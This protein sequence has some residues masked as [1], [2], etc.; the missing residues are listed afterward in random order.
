MAAPSANPFS[1]EAWLGIDEHERAGVRLL[2]L[3]HFLQGLGIAFFSTA[4]LTLF[5]HDFGPEGLAQS[6]L[7][8]GAAMLVS[9]RVYAHFEHRVELVRF[10]P[11][12]VLSLALLSLGIWSGMFLSHAPWFLFLVVAVFRVHYLISNLEF[13]GLTSLLFNVRQSKRL[14]GII[15]SADIPAKILGFLSVYLLLPFTGERDLFLLSAIFF[16]AS[17]AVVYLFLRRFAH[18]HH[19]HHHSHGHLHHSPEHFL[20]RFFGNRFILL[21]SLFAFLAG[22]VLFMLDFAFYGEVKLKFKKSE[23]LSLFLSLFLTGAMTFTFVVKLLFSSF[24]LQRAG[25]RASLLLF[26]G[27]LL[28]GS[29]AILFLPVQSGSI[30]TMLFAFMGLYVLRDAMRFTIYDPAFLSLFQ[31]LTRALRLQGHTVI[32]GMVDA[33][34]LATAGGLLLLLLHLDEN[35]EPE[36]LLRRV[37]WTMAALLALAIPAFLWAHREWVKVLHASVR[38]RFLEGDALPAADVQLRKLMAHTFKSGEPGEVIYGLRLL[39]QTNDPQYEKWLML[40]LEHAA[41]EV[42]AFVLDELKARGAHIALK[43]LTPLFSSADASVRARAL[44]WVA[45]D[46]LGWKLLPPFDEMREGGDRRSALSG[47]LSNPNAEAVD[48]GRA[49]LA[50]YFASNEAGNLRDA[51]WISGEWGLTAF[52]SEQMRLM[53]HPDPDVRGSA[54]E[55]AVKT[56][57]GDA[58]SNLIKKATL[59]PGKR[60][61]RQLLRFG[62]EHLLQGANTRTEEELALI[63]KLL[64]RTDTPA[65]IEFLSAQC[66]HDNQEVRTAAIASLHHLNHLPAGPLVHQLRLCL[67]ANHRRLSQ[68]TSW[69]GSLPQSAGV[70]NALR[71]ELAEEVSEALNTTGLLSSPAA[72]QRARQGLSAASQEMRADG[73]EL[74][75]ECLPRPLRP[76]FAQVLEHIYLHRALPASR[77]KP[78]QSEQQVLLEI[79]SSW[80]H[81]LHAWTLAAVVHALAALPADEPCTD[82][83]LPS[84]P[85]P[86][87]ALQALRDWQA[88]DAAAFNLRFPSQKLSHNLQQ[89]KPAHME[90]HASL[91]LLEK[92]AF[93]RRVSMFADTPDNVLAEVAS[94]CR[95]EPTDA[96]ILLIR[97]GDP[98]NCMYLIY[99]GAVRVE[100]E[101]QVLATFGP[102]DFFG[103]LSLLESEVRSA[104]VVTTEASLLLRIDQEDFYELIEDRAEVMRAIIVTLTRRIRN[105]N[106][107]IHSL[108]KNK[109][110]DPT[111]K[112]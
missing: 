101:R 15:G 69:I 50:L 67:N 105:Q 17:F 65:A 64:N 85:L 49:Q 84:V 56:G 9:S 103:E 26:M 109:G 36:L 24:I 3:H 4:A 107:L 30:K 6:F 83:R 88:Q 33:L 80:D 7:A 31:P 23:D 89:F 44:Q 54:L 60:M 28:A 37:L 76:L 104:D 71:I 100:Q 45:S 32:K 74:I 57:A 21:L 40:G 66:S 12:A 108:R 51:L 8:G 20:L 94:I 82:E 18:E 13:W 29:L 106:A 81:N 53:Q 61:A 25:I 1:I 73:I 46:A 102:A 93:L 62:G 95:E 98:G 19:L 14:F 72:V 70:V 5:L 96:E 43:Q 39:G 68:L 112:I 2:F 35:H 11:A 10:L 78:G 79:F 90:H 16:T 111:Q 52:A 110:P 92:V 48:A 91:S 47:L 34:A 77:L 55:A 59:G 75:E 41:G 58:I 63:C 27:L 87:M 86:S 99:N 97:K 22:I 38:K 42:V